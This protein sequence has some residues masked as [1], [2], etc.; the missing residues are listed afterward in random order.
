MT[1]RTLA[2]LKRQTLYLQQSWEAFFSHIVPLAEI[3]YAGYDPKNSSLG[4]FPQ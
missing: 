3:S 2:D 1:V 4:I